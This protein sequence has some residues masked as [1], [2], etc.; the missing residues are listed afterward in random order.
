MGVLLGVLCRPLIQDSPVAEGD[1]AAGRPARLSRDASASTPPPSGPTSAGI[2]AIAGASAAEC[3]AR[4]LEIFEADQAGMEIEL[5]A[6]FRRWLTLASPQDI[7]AELNKV[8]GHKESDWNT[9]FFHAWAALDEKAAMAETGFVQLREPRA[10]FAIQNAHPDF[11]HHL[12]HLGHWLSLDG[13]A[14]A[15]LTSLAR[16]RPDIA[17]GVVDAELPASVKSRSIT[18]VARGMAMHD[19]EA[20]LAW[21]E[22]IEDAHSGP[23]VGA[24]F[25]EWL[26]TDPEAAMMAWERHGFGDSPPDGAAMSHQLLLAMHDP[27]S[28]AG[29]LYLALHRDPFID[30]AT[31]HQ[32]L[33]ALDLDWENPGHPTPAINH[34]GWYGVDPAADAS[35]ALK[36]PAGNVRDFLLASI[37]QNWAAHDPEAALRFA[38]AHGLESRAFDDLRKAPTEEMRRTVFANPEA[39]FAALAGGA[40]PPAGASREQLY[41]LAMEWSAADPVG[42]ADWLL[43][44]DLSNWGEA[45]SLNANLWISNTIGHYWAGND[46]LGASRWMEELPEG[47]LQSRAWMAMRHEVT[48]YTP[49]LAFALSAAYVDGDSRLDLLKSALEDVRKNIGHPAALELLKSPDVSAAESRALT[50]TLK[51]AK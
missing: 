42:A 7:L 48:R 19:P 35:K 40:E 22:S 37:C 45:D 3:M 47:P 33:S 2:R 16:D 20:A 13:K 21:L 23:Q 34:D 41:T 43:T 4:V 17:R 32:Q 14:G 38:D 15:A 1:D 6:V 46:P 36:L 5:E 51:A 11:A 18:A 29:R 10:Y 9:A 26:R 49:D 50:E 39:H 12:K 31:L 8:S 24:V 44:Q 27:R 28:A 25:S 30:P